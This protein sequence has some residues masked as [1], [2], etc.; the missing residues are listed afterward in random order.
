MK[1]TASFKKYDAC[2]R[3]LNEYIGH[4]K[5]YEQFR[6]KI[7][8]R[9]KPVEVEP[10]YVTAP[11]SK[12]KAN[13]QEK[14]LTTEPQIVYEEQLISVTPAEEE[15]ELEE[16]APTQELFEQDDEEPG[17]NTDLVHL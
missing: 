13:G 6:D 3:S 7:R 12:D 8:R 2:N 16:E 17:L 14:L 5:S 4:F 11:V 15:E 10:Q 1:D 9:I